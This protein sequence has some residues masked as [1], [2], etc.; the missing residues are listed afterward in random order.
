MNHIDR[1]IP[2]TLV[3]PGMP[4][5]QE[6]QSS[7][8][9]TSHQQQRLRAIA[10]EYATLFDQSQATQAMHQAVTEMLNAFVASGM[11]LEPALDKLSVA[12]SLTY[13]KLFG[14]EQKH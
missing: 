2:S 12:M 6:T 3:V 8:T 10:D 11:G 5:K 4:S 9:L 7:P 13:A 1:E 14:G